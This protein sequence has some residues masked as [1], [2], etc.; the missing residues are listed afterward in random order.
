[1]LQFVSNIEAQGKTDYQIAVAALR[2]H[3]QTLYQL[4]RLHD[5]FITSF[6]FLQGGVGGVKIYK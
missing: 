1:M 6:F 4:L 5:N 3:W 2:P